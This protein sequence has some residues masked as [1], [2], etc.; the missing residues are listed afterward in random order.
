MQGVRNACLLQNEDNS[1]R[2]QQQLTPAVKPDDYNGM[3]LAEGVRRAS[4]SVV[5]AEPK[6]VPTGVGIV[7]QKQGVHT[8]GSGD[9]S[10]R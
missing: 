3:T 8:V 9:N 1:H 10:S 7:P 6:D 4:K 5:L 2:V